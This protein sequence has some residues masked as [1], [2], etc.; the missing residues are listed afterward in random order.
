MI[1]KGE[2][3]IIDYHVPFDQGL[4]LVLRQRY[5]GLGNGHK[6]PFALLYLKIIHR[7]GGKYPPLSATLR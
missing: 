5:K 2:S 1:V 6:S 3:T 7:S 4:R